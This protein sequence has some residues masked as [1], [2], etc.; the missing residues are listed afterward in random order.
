ML[1][2]Y[3]NKSCLFLIIFCGVAPLSITAQETNSH[4]SGIVK[5]ER[6]EILGGATVVAVHEPT[7]NRY[8]TTT[9][10]SGYFYFF[11]LKPGGPYTITISFAGYTSVKRSSLYVSYSST[12]F[13]SMLQDNDF[14]EFILKE[15]NNILPEIILVGKKV[16]QPALGVETNL[17]NQ[18]M[19]SLP[20]ISRNLQDYVRLVP[21]AKVN[22][23]GMMS[24]AG[25]NNKYNAFYIDGS[26]NNDILGIALSGTNGGQTAS[27][28]ISIEAIEE[29]N[30]SLAPYEVQYS[31]FT[32]ASVNAITKSG[33]NQFKAS[34]WY[35]FRNEQMAGRSP[36]PVDPS[37]SRPKLSSFF[38]QTGGISISGPL[39]KNKLFYFSLFEKQDELQPQPFVFS[40]YHGNSSQ[41]QLEALA[42]FVKSTYHYDPGSFLETKNQLNATRFMTKVDWNP[43]EKNKF[44]L[45][46]RYNFAERLTPQT[47]NGSTAIRFSNNGFVVPIR[48]HSAS[49][50][51][52]TFLRRAMNNRLLLTY[53]NQMVD[54]GIIGQPF[55]TVNIRDGSGSVV[56]GT[57]PN[58][59]INLFKATDFTLLDAFKFISRK[60]VF[61][62]GIDLNFSKLN[63]L[64]LPSYFGFYR[65]R[66]INDFMFNAFPTAFERTVSLVDEPINDNT[67]AAGVFNTKK[68]GLFINDD[69]QI[70]PFFLLSFGFR[71]DGNSLPS[72]YK[73]DDFFNTVAIPAIESYYDLDG[74]RSGQMMRTH[75]QPAPRFGMVY[76]LPTENITVR[77]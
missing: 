48:T 24:F 54:A 6:N 50:E 75:W 31:N 73:A 41:Q 63:D 57:N 60:Q 7:K 8:A 76:K 53:T 19:N 59:Q 32:G 3:G 4:I 30:V 70:N 9:L 21:Q 43:S 26:N 36:I 34:A 1:D 5:S 46:Y 16:K 67:K 33:T 38:N 44:T 28:P 45:S 55:P 29:I 10:A 15:N 13:F 35:F 52:K 42:N 69:I 77:S 40:Q 66:N 47:V 14:S 18:Q 20:S 39:I 51:W 2:L 25:Q 12:N 62:S 22:G 11:N 72:S 64:I 74:A 23:D 17:T 49:F 58:T 27:P 61:T 37:G 56:V 65:F 68:L 71:I